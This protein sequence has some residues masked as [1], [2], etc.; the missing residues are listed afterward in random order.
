MPG[1]LQQDVNRL[2]PSAAS[3]Q[4]PSVVSHLWGP[5]QAARSPAASAAAAPTK[6]DKRRAKQAKKAEEAE[7]GAAQVC[8]PVYLLS[9]ALTLPID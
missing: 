7:H 6:R 3:T 1:R 5:A 2:R 4:A 9:P 8:A